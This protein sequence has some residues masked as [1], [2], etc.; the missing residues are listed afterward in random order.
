VGGVIFVDIFLFF[1]GSE[2]L[3]IEGICFWNIIDLY[4][5]IF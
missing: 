5:V 2:F 4:T 1:Y 3:V